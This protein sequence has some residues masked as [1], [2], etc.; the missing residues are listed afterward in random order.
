M[1]VSWG[2][3]TGRWNRRRVPHPG[4][5]GGQ[6]EEGIVCCIDGHCGLTLSDHEM[7]SMLA[8]PPSPLT[9]F[10]LVALDFIRGGE[11][12]GG[13]AVQI[14]HEPTFEIRR[15]SEKKNPT[16]LN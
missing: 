5:G 3:L 16:F 6:D 8:V 4:E 10:S 9:K 13:V 15:F 2:P 12:G 1:D 7:G 11:N 14:I